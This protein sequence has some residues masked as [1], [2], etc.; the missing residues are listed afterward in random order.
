ASIPP[1][2]VGK[3]GISSLLSL[4][5]LK[6]FTNQISLNNFRERVITGDSGIDF[7]IYS[8]QSITL[9]HFLNKKLMFLMSF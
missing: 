7:F 9:I 2:P 1:S 4:F 5:S 8:P 6:N 3:V